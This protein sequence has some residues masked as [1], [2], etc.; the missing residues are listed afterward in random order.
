MKVVAIKA[1]LDVEVEEIH[2]IKME[3]IKIALEEVI[4]A[5]IGVV[6]I[7]EG[8]EILVAE[9]N[10]LA[11]ERTV[12][13]GITAAEEIMAAEV[14]NR[15]VAG[16]AKTTAVDSVAE[17]EMTKILTTTKTNSKDSE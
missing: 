16:M 4:V 9:E 10:M 17:T 8:E 3:V 11:E 5:I 1:V 14:I 12:A 2:S 6:E 13:K 7:I 15:V